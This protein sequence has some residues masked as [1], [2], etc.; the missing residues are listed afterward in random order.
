M[1]TSFDFLPRV[2]VPGSRSRAVWAPSQSPWG[3]SL[4][5]VPA[6]KS[7]SRSVASAH[8]TF[9]KIIKL[10]WKYVDLAPIGVGERGAARPL[11]GSQDG[12]RVVLVRFL[13]RLAVWDRFCTLF[14]PSWDHFWP[15]V[16]PCSAFLGPIF[17]SWVPF[18]CF[19]LLWG[20]MF[21]CHLSIC[22]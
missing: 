4:G 6:P 17:G 1:Y 22:F 14:G 8:G 18:W 12:L 5:G 20:S 19:F 2:W 11:G 7:A 3:A 16:V 13:L 15:L 10:L 21:V 9:L